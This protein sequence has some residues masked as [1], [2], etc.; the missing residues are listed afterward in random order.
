[1]DYPP[2]IQELLE[3]YWKTE[4][5]VAEEKELRN[6]FVLH[7]EHGDQSTAYFQFLQLESSIESPQIVAPV[8]AH[9]RRP[10]IMRIVSIA[11]AVLLLVTAGI[12]FDKQSDGEV[13]TNHA[14]VDSYDDPNAAYQEAKEAL[15]LISEKLNSSTKKASEQIAKTK[16]YTEILK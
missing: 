8:V 16:P 12:I 4:T 3:K 14:V 10:R 9:N 13:A 5:T 15:M 2:R 1:M 6:Y 7:P 11:A